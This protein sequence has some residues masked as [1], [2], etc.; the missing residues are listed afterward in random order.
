[1]E[2][3]SPDTPGAE[4]D[5]TSDKD[6]KV[7]KES[8][9]SLLNKSFE[10][11]KKEDAAG[12]LQELPIWERLIPKP[13]RE[14][15][16]EPKADAQAENR[17][18]AA[19]ASL[20]NLS[21]TEQAEVAQAYAREKLNKLSNESQ[22][23]PDT[24]EAA[25][26]Q[27]AREF[28][29]NVAER[30]LSIPEII[31]TDF[32]ESDS[33]V[34]DVETRQPEDIAEAPAVEPDPEMASEALAYFSSSEAPTEL[35]HDMELNLGPE[36]S[37]EAT[38]EEDVE[39]HSQT[40]ASRPATSGGNQGGANQPPLPPGMRGGSANPNFNRAPVSTEAAPVS[41]ENNYYDDNAGS[42]LLAGGILGYMLGRRGR[43]KTERKLKA[44]SKRLESQ[45]RQT[46][47][48]IDNQAKVVRQQ[49]R[50]QYRQSARLSKVEA[51]PKVEA[52]S[53]AAVEALDRSVPPESIR[54]M[55]QPE[56]L[57]LAER[58]DVD[59]TSLRTIFEARQITEPG[60]RRIAGEYMRG[61]DVK[62]AVQQERMVKEM[63]FE[64]DPQ[65]RDRLAASY[66]EVDAAQPQSA[67]QGLASLLG[68]PVQA[69]QSTQPPPPAAQ[70]N[71]QPPNRSGQQILISA[72][73]A[74]VILLVI[75]VVVLALR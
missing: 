9:G 45:I 11:S 51:A 60:L 66:A 12:K 20:E 71:R 63:Q 54:S 75:I 59:G 3:Y 21:A 39:A 8:V 24:E 50:E 30:P 34:A 29:E 7:S 36:R 49:A 32:P 67:Q 72:W 27:A 33:E 35:R 18:E 70:P 52:P 16:E 22:A 73:V 13:S 43:I 56:L 37:V 65:M 1:M 57:A 46:Q 6:K 48:R 10:S 5:K 14:K 38:D 74:M 55:Q 23:A 25:A 31:T 2:G 42:A 68:S 44:V 64:R 19:D 17:E 40:S 53:P 41:V 69:A 61:G 26:E 47:E 15:A 62:K 28:Y 58:I 4:K